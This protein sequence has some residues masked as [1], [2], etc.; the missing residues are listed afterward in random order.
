[1]R[2]NG[3]FEFLAHTIELTDPRVDRG[4]KCFVED[5][6]YLFTKLFFVNGHL[7]ARTDCICVTLQMFGQ[8]VPYAR[9]N[10]FCR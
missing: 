7:L 10:L 3:F 2:T 8:G 6:I 1:M 5:L 9:P 4:Y